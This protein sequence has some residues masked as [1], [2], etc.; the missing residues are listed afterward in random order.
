MLPSGAEGG[1][2]APERTKTPAGF[3]GGGFE[4][5]FPLSRDR[6][7]CRYLISW[8]YGTFFSDHFLLLRSYT[9]L[10]KHFQFWSSM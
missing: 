5:G 1:Q 4:D 2:A 7:L 3:P 8:T 6:R 10:V 9:E